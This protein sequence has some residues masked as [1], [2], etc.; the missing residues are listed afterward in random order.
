M[1]DM[2]RRPAFDLFQYLG[3]GCWREPARA[4]RGEAIAAVHLGL[5]RIAKGRPGRRRRH[6]EATRRKQ[7]HA[8]NQPWLIDCQTARATVAESMSEH[9]PRTTADRLNVASDVTGQ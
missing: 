3:I 1:G 7:H 5:R 6:D 2:D 8:P 4:Q 9:V